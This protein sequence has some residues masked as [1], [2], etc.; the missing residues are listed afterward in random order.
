MSNSKLVDCTVKSPN[1]SGK[2]THKIDRITPHCVVGQLYAESIG[3][4]L[5]KPSVRA[6]ANYGIGTDGRVCLIVDECNRSWC[7]S[8][9]DND[10]RAVTIE[11]ASDLKHPYAM[12]KKVYNKLVDLCVDICKRNGIK[13]LLFLGN[14]EKSLAYKP[15]SGEAVLTAHKWFANKAC[16]GEWLYSRY[17]DLAKEVT[18]KLG[19]KTTTTTT[20]TSSS[21]GNKIVAKGQAH[22]NNYV[23]DKI[24]TDGIRGPQTKKQG[25]IVLQHSMNLDYKSGLTENGVF[26]SATAKALKGH[27]VKKYEKQY[28]VTACEILLMLKGYDP[29]GVEK[30]GHFGD[31]LLASVKQYQKDHNLKVDG[32]CSEEMFKSLIM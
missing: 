28:M 27:Y 26:N 10:Q 9:A 12:N 4:C 6:S 3:Y 30:P 8:S 19:G 5:N 11:C 32:I 17:D 23:T 24:A 7:S 15:K 22:S 25:I 20:T 31:G 13:T 1:H 21:K 2:R 29:K 18:K 16:P 14:K